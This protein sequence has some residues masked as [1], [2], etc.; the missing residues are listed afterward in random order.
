MLL[1]IGIIGMVVFVVCCGVFLGLKEPESSEGQSMPAAEQPRFF[2]E[3][4][5]GF[6]ASDPLAVELLL[7]RLEEHIRTEEAAAEAF[8]QSPTAENLHVRTDSPWVN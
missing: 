5:T 8:L 6:E 3:Q 7:K 4:A 1:T 2:A